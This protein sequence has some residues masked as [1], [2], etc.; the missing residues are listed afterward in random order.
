V[1]L[2]LL[3]TAPL[4]L[5]LALSPAAS[6]PSGVLHR[7]VATLTWWCIIH[8]SVAL[9]VGF[10]GHFHAGALF[11]AEVLVGVIG[12]AA[13]A[14]RHGSRAARPPRDMLRQL[15]GLTDREAFTCFAMAF[16]FASSLFSA[17][18][19]V[20]TNYDSLAYHLPT[21][22]RWYQVGRFE[23]LAEYR[24]ISRYPFSWE[25][26]CALFLFPFG[27]DV[28]VV[29]PQF[30]AWIMLGGIT[31]LFSRRAGAA[32][33]LAVTAGC[34]VTSLPTVLHQLHSLHVDLAFAVVFLVALYYGLAWAHEGG[35]REAAV[36]VAAVGMLCGIK[37][38]GLV[39]Y[40]PMLV[41]VVGAVAVR[42]AVMRRSLRLEWS[43]PEWLLVFVGGVAGLTIA[44]PWYIRNLM[45]VGNPL[46]DVQVAVGRW[47]LFPGHDPAALIYQTTLAALFDFANPRHLR[48]LMY[49][50]VHYLGLSFMVAAAFMIIGLMAR[51]RGGGAAP[52]AKRLGLWIV[53]VASAVLY[54][55]TPYSGDNGTHDWQ[56]T[57][58]IGQGL[59]YAIPFAT[60]LVIISVSGLTVYARHSEALSMIAPIAA[61]AAAV[62][63]AAPL[64]V[65]T[66]FTVLWIGLVVAYVVVMRVEWS[67]T[68]AY[69][70]LLVAAAAIA[71]AA[72]PAAGALRERRAEHRREAYRG[73]SA[74]IEAT[75]GRDETIGYLLS[76]KSYLF[77]GEH[78]DRRVVYAHPDGAG[79]EDWLWRL[80]GAG[81]ALVA[82]G[83]LQGRRTADP[84]LAWLRDAEGPFRR[85]FGTDGIDAPVFYR[86]S[87]VSRPTSHP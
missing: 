36:A 64:R 69:V 45:E 24:G 37:T 66:Q 58:W 13:L 74:F 33:P 83:P 85:V 23:M 35:A 81:V 25:A 55:I 1:F 32:R 31:Y 73:V 77:Y 17:L 10:A 29:L 56:I 7:Y 60:V 71:S 51:A 6:I 43:P 52:E 53:L 49:A 65:M 3:L 42:N 50:V 18:T 34:L 57:D 68:R 4:P 12:L 72:V 5:A 27:D 54:W 59:R 87:E 67:A 28:V 21:M 47:V 30:V 61:L 2:V 80:R 48:I 70:A 26:L 38:S 75:V 20:I 46:G 76:H 8:L 40:L 41:A 44:A 16:V 9:P 86:F 14:R 19:R 39:Y 78:L 11:I 15:H 79:Y 63:S 22:A 62:Q 84:V 82:V